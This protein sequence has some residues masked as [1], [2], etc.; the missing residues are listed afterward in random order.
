MYSL[1]KGQPEAVSVRK[2]Q[3]GKE[4]KE[5]AEWPLATEVTVPGASR[6]LVW[7]EEWMGSGKEQ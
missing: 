4:M 2:Q 1:K 5:A 7:L 6:K 3:A